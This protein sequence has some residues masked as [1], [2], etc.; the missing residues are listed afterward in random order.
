MI[1]DYNENINFGQYRKLSVKEIYQGTLN[2]NKS[3][4]AAYLD[5][6]L[7]K[8]NH[9][10]GIFKEKEF[11]ERYEINENSISI[12][13]EIHNEEK[14]KSVDNRVVFGNIQEILSSFI[15]MHFN[16]NS[17]GILLDIRSFNKSQITPYQIGG[18]PEYLEWCEKTI[19]NFKLSLDCK[20]KLEQFPVARLTGVSLLYIGQESYEYAPL[21]QV[22]KFTFK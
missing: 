7:N 16:D 11:I 10:A 12:I 21:Y 4:L 5:Q 3:F 9:V 2:L 14:P 8:Q 6:I 1:T 13:G 18:D 22:E 20:N 15:N 19:D 17:L